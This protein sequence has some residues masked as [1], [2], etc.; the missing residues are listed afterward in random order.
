MKN[1]QICH[2]CSPKL[3]HPHHHHSQPAS[4]TKN[5][6]NSPT[7]PPTHTSTPLELYTILHQ[8]S[9]T[10]KY[11]KTK[12]IHH[13]TL[14]NKIFLYV[15]K[16]PIY[17]QSSRPNALKPARINLF[18]QSGSK[19]AKTWDPKMYAFR[20]SLLTPLLWQQGGWEL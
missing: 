13:P 11:I 17:S 10:L 16:D 3:Q 5:L 14:S 1:H 8:I 9:S 20:A 4:Q 12:A 2:F 18:Q 6:T 7:Q 15:Y 19:Y